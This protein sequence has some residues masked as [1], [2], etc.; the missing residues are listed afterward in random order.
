MRCGSDDAE[1]LSVGHAIMAP[2]TTGDPWRP[3]AARKMTT[4]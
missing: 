1:N 3:P 4:R 2:V